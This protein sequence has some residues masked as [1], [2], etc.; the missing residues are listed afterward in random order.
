VGPLRREKFADVAGRS[1]DVGCPGE[2]AGGQIAANSRVV[3]VTATSLRTMHVIVDLLD[4]PDER[5]AIA[6]QAV[7]LL[8]FLDDQWPLVARGIGT[9]GT[10][11]SHSSVES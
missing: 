10:C 9:A 3:A 7:A 1:A 5:E 2:G 11:D 8:G 4:Q 6:R